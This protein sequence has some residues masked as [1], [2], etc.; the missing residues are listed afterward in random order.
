MSASSQSVSAS[1]HKAECK[2]MTHKC[3]MCVDDREGAETRFKRIAEAYEV[4]SDPSARKHYDHVRTKESDFRSRGGA[5]AFKES[6]RTAEEVLSSRV[7][8][9]L[10]ISSG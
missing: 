9:S 8:M 6:F 3:G 4:L 7:L 10:S 2:D 1:R 5:S